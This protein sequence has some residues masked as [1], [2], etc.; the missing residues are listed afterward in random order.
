MMIYTR[1]ILQLEYEK[2]GKTAAYGSRHF[3]E[4]D[5]AVH[6]IAG[7]S[8]WNPEMFRNHFTGPKILY[9][10]SKCENIY[11]QFCDVNHWECYAFNLREEVIH[12]LDSSKSSN[13]DGVHPGS[14]HHW[15][16]P[17]LA[18]AMQECLA[19][20]FADWSGDVT[21]WEYKQPVVPTQSFEVESGVYTLE[22]MKNWN[23]TKCTKLLNPGC[24]DA[25]R[26]D[27]VMDILSI[28]ENAA[29]LPSF[30]QELMKQY[31]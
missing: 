31:I 10:V 6:A 29:E 17:M 14:K 12:I 5:F 21:K 27:I 24:I 9:N 11:V 3:L 1:R 26:T 8:L 13:H 16:V 30:V 4:A 15:I 18:R 23:G 25:V 2:F 7:D 28:K 19:L 20:F 22:F